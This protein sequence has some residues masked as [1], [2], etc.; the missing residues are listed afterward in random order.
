MTLVSGCEGDFAGLA[1]STARSDESWIVA[2]E[3]LASTM[4]VNGKVE[5]GE[6]N[7]DLPWSISIDDLSRAAM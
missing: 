5:P 6:D 4:R 1:V 7:V 3:A 2:L